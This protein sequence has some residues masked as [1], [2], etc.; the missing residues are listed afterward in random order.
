M[1]PGTAL[2]SR[3]LVANPET[4]EFSFDTVDVCEG[5]GHGLIERFGQPGQRM[6]VSRRSSWDD[7]GPVA[8]QPAAVDASGPADA[9]RISTAGRDVSR[10]TVHRG[11]GC[12]RRA[13][14]RVTG[15]RGRGVGQ[16]T[17]RPPTV[18]G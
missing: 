10:G 16:V 5:R 12:A 13:H 14:G 18:T 1:S 4:L 17:L 15:T 8:P 11:A 2:D 6:P 3:G 7:H 9:V